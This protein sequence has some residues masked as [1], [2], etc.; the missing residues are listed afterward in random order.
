MSVLF[1]GLEELKRMKAEAGIGVED[2]VIQ[3]AG[4]H[5]CDFGDPTV[6]TAESPNNDPLINLITMDDIVNHV[7]DPTLQL[8]GDGHIIK[9][10]DRVHVIAGYAGV[11][12]SRAANYLAYCGATGKRWFE[13][14]V[15]HKFKTLFIQSENGMTRLK[16]DLSEL[17]NELKDHVFFVDAPRGFDFGNHQFRDK[18]RT[19]IEENNIGMVVIDPWTNLVPDIG[20]KEFNLAIDLVMDCMP[21]NPSKC[22]AVMIVAHCRKP[23]GKGKI[24]RGSELMHEVYGSHVLTSR[25][26]FVLIM[27]RANMADETDDRVLTTCAKANDAQHMPKG[28]HNRGK[29]IFEP[30][31]DFD[32]D[33]REAP[34]KAG[35]KSIYSLSEVVGLMPVGEDFK[36]SDW[37][38]KAEEVFGIKASRFYEF[39]SEAVSMERVVKLDKRGVY[40]RVV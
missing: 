33:E 30:V 38:K 40:R 23:D 24:K 19:I 35:T 10:K 16:D 31:E 3:H 8:V 9:G 22:P 32:W 25:S 20:H 17:V 12:K 4:D 36:S 39:Q 7:N 13:Y 37:K 6:A 29:V 5:A 2:S 1:E 18:L 27:E 28:C 11:G 15:K 34:I 21:M 14:E 26:R